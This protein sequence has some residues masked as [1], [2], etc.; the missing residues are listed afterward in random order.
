M[1]HEGPETTRFRVSELRRR[2]PGLGGSRD[3]SDDEKLF[4]PIPNLAMHKEHETKRRCLQIAVA[5]IGS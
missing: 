3:G 1:A 5:L 2:N 4:R